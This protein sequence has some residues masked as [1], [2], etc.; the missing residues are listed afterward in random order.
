MAGC[1]LV[2]LYERSALP[3]AASYPGVNGAATQA[4]PGIEQLVWREFF[5]GAGLQE[6][7]VQ[8]LENNR[9]LRIAMQRVEEARGLYG[10]PDKECG[11]RVLVIL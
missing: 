4:S 3:T 6:L 10:I 2:P 9:D 11:G 1:S 7:I 8:A 5:T